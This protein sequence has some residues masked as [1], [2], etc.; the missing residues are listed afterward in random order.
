MKS[1]N[2]L[3]LMKTN[4]FKLSIHKR[5]TNWK[6]NQLINFKYLKMYSIISPNCFFFTIRN[7]TESC[8]IKISLF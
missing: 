7:I 3:C 2:N 6:L 8:Y 5:S 4:Q 1:L